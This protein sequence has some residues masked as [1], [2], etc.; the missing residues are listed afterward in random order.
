M[1]IRN[2]FTAIVLML[3]ANFVY[4]ASAVVYDPVSN[5]RKT[6]N[7]AILCK[8]N[9]IKKINVHSSDQNGWY[10][11]SVCGEKGV[12]HQS[13]IVFM[14]G[15]DIG[16]VYDPVSN[17]RKVPNGKILCK[18]KTIS[19]MRVASY[20]NE[21]YATNFCGEIGV[22]HQSQIKLVSNEVP[23]KSF[24]SN[25]SYH[26]NSCSDRTTMCLALTWGPDVCSSV[27][28][29]YAEKKLD[30]KVH[31][32]IVSPGCLVAISKYYKQE[33]SASDLL[34]SM[35]TGFLDEYGSSKIRS[36]DTGDKVAGGASYLAS[37]F[38]KYNMYKSCMNKCQ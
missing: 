19:A 10:E 26:A 25:S 11:T 2:I 22:I 36:D 14:S 12:I 21:W 17:I 5:V 27:F 18:V 7:G 23:S 34:L 29:A 13:Q 35:L 8:I 33:Y 3:C 20:D 31:D 16:I 32:V 38:I 4:A 9:R 30:S 28:N 6:P 37:H 24:E 1:I 15:K